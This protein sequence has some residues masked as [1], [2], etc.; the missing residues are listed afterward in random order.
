[1]TTISRVKSAVHFGDGVQQLSEWNVSLDRLSASDRQ[2]AE[3]W[4]KNAGAEIFV[5]IVLG[6]A[7]TKGK[8]RTALG[9]EHML[10]EAAGILL[11]DPDLTPGTAA[12]IVAHRVVAEGDWRGRVK[13]TEEGLSNWIQ[14]RLKLRQSAMERQATRRA[15][16]LRAVTKPA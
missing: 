13:I 14:A 5:R 3:Q 6:V 16:A 9:G 1:M 10:V 2:I 11:T 8:G 4:I 15:A 7:A 12:S